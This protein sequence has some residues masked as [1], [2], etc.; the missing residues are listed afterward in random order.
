ML[1]L[2]T[3][4]FALMLHGTFFGAKLRSSCP[5]FALEMNSQKRRA[6]SDVAG[7]RVSRSISLKFRPLPRHP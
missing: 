6:F 2:A 3:F 5:W 7:D 1:E 4:A